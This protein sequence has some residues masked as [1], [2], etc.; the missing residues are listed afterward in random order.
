MWGFWLSV[1]PVL[2][3]KLSQT[4]HLVGRWDQWGMA[5][6]SNLFLVIGDYCCWARWFFPRPSCKPWVISGMEKVSKPDIIKSLTWGI[7]SQNSHLPCTDTGQGR[8][9]AKSAPSPWHCLFRKSPDLLR[10]KPALDS[11]RRLLISSF[12]PL[13]CSA[14][15]SQSCCQLP[16]DIPTVRSPHGNALC[17]CCQTSCLSKLSLKAPHDPDPDNSENFR[18]HSLSVLDIWKGGLDKTQRRMVWPHRWPWF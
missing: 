14:H 3:E 15:H 11:P 2:E 17:P 5:E 13:S 7:I 9:T 6:E 1:A 18:G 4:E 8:P 10:N 16:L 12:S